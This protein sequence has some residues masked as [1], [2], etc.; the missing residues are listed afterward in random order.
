MKYKCSTCGKEH[1]DFPALVFSS[2]YYYNRLSE[3]DKEK[4]ANLNSD[5]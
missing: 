1:E 4:L 2:P 5:L 3:E